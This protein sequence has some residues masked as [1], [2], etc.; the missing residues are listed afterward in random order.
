MQK[1]KQGLKA[2]NSNGRHEKIRQSAALWFVALTESF[3]APLPLRSPSPRIPNPALRKPMSPSSSSLSAR[4]GSSP[5]PAKRAMAKPV[6]PVALGFENLTALRAAHSRETKKKKNGGRKP[7]RLY[8]LGKGSRTIDLTPYEHSG[9]RKKRDYTKLRHMSALE[10]KTSEQDEQEDVIEDMTVGDA[11]AGVST[12]TGGS[13]SA[14]VTAERSVCKLVAKWQGSTIELPV[15]PTS[16]TIGEVKVNPAVAEHACMYIFFPDQLIVGQI[17]LQ[18]RSHNCCL[19]PYRL[20]GP[21]FFHVDNNRVYINRGFFKFSDY[22]PAQYYCCCTATT[23][24]V[25]PTS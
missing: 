7:G 2:K 23:V 10:L 14:S 12:G 19:E 21:F 6:H 13:G 17:A 20:L 8:L 4:I 1:Y 3:P 18:R 24:V 11:G 16:T 15:L 25:K 22:Q 9:E 5:N